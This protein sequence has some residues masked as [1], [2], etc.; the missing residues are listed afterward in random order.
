MGKLESTLKTSFPKWWCLEKVCL[1][2]H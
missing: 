2:G 1:F